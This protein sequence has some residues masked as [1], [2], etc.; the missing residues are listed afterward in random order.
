MYNTISL[1]TLL[2]NVLRY[3]KY[4][5]IKSISLVTFGAGPISFLNE[6]QGLARGLVIIIVF[7][8]TIDFM[9]ILRGND[10]H[11]VSVRVLHLYSQFS[12]TKDKIKLHIYRFLW[13]TK[14]MMSFLDRYQF[15]F[16]AVRTYLFF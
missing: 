8:S 16:M 14:F 5:T 2:W 1:Y 6:L 11:W 3:L 7:D 13:I 9:F 15:F 12:V 10:H 4:Q